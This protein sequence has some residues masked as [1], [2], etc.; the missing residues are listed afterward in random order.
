M[1]ISKVFLLILFR[2]SELSVFFKNRRKMVTCV[3]GSNSSAGL[4]KII[5]PDLFLAVV[6][7]IFVDEAGFVDQRLCFNIYAEQHSCAVTVKPRYH[8]LFQSC[9]VCAVDKKSVSLFTLILSTRK[10]R[11][12]VFVLRRSPPCTIHNQVIW[13]Q[14]VREC[15]RSA[16]YPFEIVF[17]HRVFTRL[18]S[19]PTLT[20]LHFPSLLTQ[21][22]QLIRTVNASQ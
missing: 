14:L 8:S 9:A 16:T 13:Y 15:R 4:L 19:F 12:P 5:G 21:T 18:P 6:W 2:V 11:Y 20:F 17:V 10:E 1:E 3:D 7:V 22:C